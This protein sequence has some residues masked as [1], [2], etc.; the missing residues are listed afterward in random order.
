MRLWRPRRSSASSLAADWAGVGSEALAG[1]LQRTIAAD[2]P[3]GSSATSAASATDAVSGT[4]A[5]GAP[6]D[7]AETPKEQPVASVVLGLLT[8]R[9]PYECAPALARR[10]AL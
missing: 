8:A 6:S 3:L 9:V 5:A 1:W 4:S 10:Y 7:D 2:I